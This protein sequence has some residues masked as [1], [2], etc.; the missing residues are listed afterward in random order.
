MSESTNRNEPT[1]DDPS[2]KPARSSFRDALRGLG[3]AASEVAGAGAEEARKLAETARP[4]V[5]RRAQQAKA[6]A[7]AARP[8]IER[9]AREATDYVRE[10]QDEIVRA[11]KHG[12]GVAASGAARAV[13]PGPL[14][15]AV[16]A[17]QRELRKPA[18]ESTDDADNEAPAATGNVEPATSPDPSDL[19]EPA[20]HP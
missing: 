11:S 17:M 20:D 19:T 7:E 6:A 15:P 12:A 2:G 13:T 4:E 3:R 9:K 16:D 8:H 1:G 14:R 18:Q 5:E 10:H